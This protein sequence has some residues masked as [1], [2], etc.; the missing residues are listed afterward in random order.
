MSTPLLKLV[1]L[2][3]C[4]W[5]V[6]ASVRCGTTA[7]MSRFDTDSLACTSHIWICFKCNTQN[8][9]NTSF[10]FASRTQLS[11]QNSFNPLSSIPAEQDGVFLSSPLDHQ[12]SPPLF[13]TP[14]GSTKHSSTRVSSSILSEKIELNRGLTSH[15]TATVISVT[16]ANVHWRQ[17]HKLLSQY[18]H[19]YSTMCNNV[20]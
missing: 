10:Q 20:Q 4:L 16:Y 19:R 17:L 14:T 6:W 12:F 3:H 5:R 11:I 9:S 7:P 2:M 13:S 1:K 18:T 8:F 15:S